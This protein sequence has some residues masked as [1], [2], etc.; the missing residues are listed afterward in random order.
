MPRRI[1]SR[2]AASEWQAGPM[3]QMILARRFTA[4][5]GNSEEESFARS[6]LSFAI[7]DLRCFMG[8]KSGSVQPGRDYCNRCAVLLMSANQSL[9]AAIFR[10]VDLRYKLGDYTVGRCDF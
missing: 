4:I 6:G 8:S 10:V 9:D 1:K 2:M 5:T 3:V 7:S